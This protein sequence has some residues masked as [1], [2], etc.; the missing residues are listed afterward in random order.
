MEYVY[1][2]SHI[3]GLRVITK[4]LSTHQKECVYAVDNEVI[5]MLFAC[6][7]NSHGDYD[8]NISIEND[9]PVLVERWPGVL[10]K[11]YST[12]ASLYKLNAKNFNHYNFL[13]KPE[14][15]SYCDEPVLEEIP[16]KNVLTKLQEYQKDNKLKI[17]VFPNRPDYIPLDN[18]DLILRAKKFESMGIENAVEEL[19][20]LY[21]QL[22]DVAVSN[23]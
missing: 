9:M 2:G 19:F 3:S 22:R 23:T 11:I 17:Y 16:I 12:Q 15:I 5:A 6:N 7:E 18:S 13:W 14:V 1:H 20:T 4:H 21:P 10:E 8:V